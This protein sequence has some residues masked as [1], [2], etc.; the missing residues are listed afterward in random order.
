VASAYPRIVSTCLQVYKIGSVMYVACLP[1]GVP[2]QPRAYHNMVVVG[3]RLIVIGGKDSTDE[4]NVGGNDLVGTDTSSR[5]HPY[6]DY[7]L[8]S[9]CY[10]YVCIFRTSA[11]GR[12]TLTQHILI[13]LCRGSRWV[14]M[15]RKGTRGSIRNVSA[16]Q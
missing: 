12:P 16:L 9:T 7:E 11:H 10:L 3:P 13:T 14:S 6:I 2:P 8:C 1:T 4:P 15:I 5:A